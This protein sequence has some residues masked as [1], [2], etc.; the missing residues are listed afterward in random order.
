[1]NPIY[2]FEL[3]LNLNGVATPYNVSPRFGN[4]LT[5]EYSLHENEMF[6]RASLNGRLTFVGRDFLLIREANFE[7]QFVL[8]IRISW[9]YG[10]TWLLYWRGQF[11]KTDCDFDEDNA[12]VTVAPSILDEY[13]DVLAG[14]DKE[15][16]LISLRPV[17]ERLTVTKRPLIQIYVPGESVVSCFLGGMSWEQDCEPVSSGYDLMTKFKF[18][19]ISER[20]DQQVVSGSGVADGYWLNGVSPD[21]RYRFERE[22]EYED[23]RDIYYIYLTRI[24]DGKRLFVNRS[25]YERGD[26]FDMWKID[27]RYYRRP[28]VKVAGVNITV[29]ARYLCDVEK[30]GTQTTYPISVDDFSYDNRNYRRVA[31]YGNTDVVYYD[32]TVSATPTEYG[33]RKPGEYWVAPQIAGISAFYPVGRSH[34]GAYSIWFAF[35]ATDKADEIA[36]RKE[37]ALRD[38]NPLSSVISVLLSQIA[39]GITHEA[40]PA[41]SQFL[42]DTINPISGRSF[43]LM[44]TQKSNL[45]AGDYSQPAQK[46]PITLKMVLEMLRNCFRAYWFIED[47]KFRIEHIEYFRN[48]GSYTTVP[49]V[50]ADLTTAESVPTAKAWAFA[51]NKYT[52]DKST[53]PERY[54]FGWMDDTT[55]A[56]EGFPIEVQSRFVEPGNIEEIRINNF[57]PDVDLML[58]NPGAFS[59]DGFAIFGAVERSLVTPDTEYRR[60]SIGSPY[61]VVYDIRNTLPGDALKIRLEASGNIINTCEVL[62]VDES[63]TA[64]ESIGQFV[65]ASINTFEFDTNV[66]NNAV[67]IAV[68]QISTLGET[69]VRVLSIDGNKF[70]SFDEKTIDGVN[71]TIQNGLLAFVNLQPD[72]YLYDMPCYRVVVNKQAVNA[73][74][75]K[76]NKK[77][78]VSFPVHGD[79]DVMRLVKTYIGD[80]QIEKV[81]VNLSSRQANATLMY[82]TYKINE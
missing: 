78:D 10:Q 65:A 48:G 59:K 27:D 4:D 5:K 13:A 44:I 35:S 58:L 16:D 9:D 42:Y 15:Y 8:T 6:Y 14:L 33:I 55:T 29:Y 81:S 43:E 75:I 40:T 54:Q 1:M 67:G 11:Y 20:D 7:T 79:P 3:A 66:P 18:S 80:G 57:N 46:A 50:G 17:I 31:P 70:L 25:E 47:G 71:Y 24:S 28:V 56:F 62:F 68:T 61:N 51:T 64:I 82:D 77:Q 72:Y 73:Y 76:R 12:T 38:A 30:I 21:G 52:Y 32:T 22:T 63:G 60:I 74:G 23:E 2:N 19:K 37:Y 36:G 39:P 45:L 69:R 34:W 53:L 26:T 41:Y 49:G